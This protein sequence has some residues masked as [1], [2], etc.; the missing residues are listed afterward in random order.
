MDSMG[1]FML[2]TKSGT[3]ARNCD[4][5][6]Q[7]SGLENKLK[8]LHEVISDQFLMQLLPLYISFDS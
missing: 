8:S 3:A 6:L 2:S 1:F 4:G 7:L 5:L